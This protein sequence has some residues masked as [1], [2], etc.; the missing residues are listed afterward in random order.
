MM[1]RVLEGL[2]PHPNLEYMGIF[3]YPGSELPSWMLKD[4]DLILSNLV[5]LKLIYF[6]KCNQLPHTLGKLPSFKELDIIGINEVTYIGS[7]FSGV[8]GDGDSGNNGGVKI[9]FSKVKLL[10]IKYMDNLEELY[11]G[12]KKTKNKRWKENYF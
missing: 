8:F 6:K 5:S 1:D 7:E 3:W 4:D 12:T 11:L 10:S 9:A 2:Q